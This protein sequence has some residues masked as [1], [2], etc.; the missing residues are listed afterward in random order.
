MPWDIRKRGTK[1]CVVKQGESKPVPG[2]CHNSRAEAER[3][4]RALYASEGSY[5]VKTMETTTGNNG[6]WTFLGPG[7]TTGTFSNVTI[8]VSDAA[9][10]TAEEQEFSQWEGI[11]GIEGHVTGDRRYLMPGGIEERDLPLTLMVQ[12]VNEE[13]HKGSEVGGR[14]DAISRIS[15]EE[16]REQGYKLDDVSDDAVVI[17]AQGIFDN[18]EF[19]SESARMVDDEVLRGISVDLAP[20][21][22]L[23]LDPET[24]EEVDTS[25]LD[26][27]EIL[28]GDFV[29]GIK[30]HI[31]GATVVPFAAF[32]EA[33]IRTLT[34]SGKPGVLTFF[35][36]FGIKI[37]KA[38]ALTAS[39]A[40]ISS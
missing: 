30:G 36:P 38:A 26:L 6:L 32:E 40:L 8:T 25:E 3:H 10:E 27:F 29:Q 14:I 12:T 20:T 9:E 7:T 34:A 19:G 31:M 13:G 11:L 15:P 16:A 22:V 4:R 33:V 21:E 23:L 39:A 2:G 24:Y 35:S 28:M 5:T 17:M 18:S 37:T 1:Y